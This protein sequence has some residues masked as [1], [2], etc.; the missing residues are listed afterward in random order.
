MRGNSY[1][2]NAATLGI[3]FNTAMKMALILVAA[4]ASVADIGSAQTFHKTKMLNSKGREVP[5]DLRFD[6]QS[7]LLTVKPRKSTIPDVP[8]GAIDKLSYERASHRR[9]KD[10]LGPSVIACA[11]TPVVY[12]TCPTSL[13]VGAVL[14]LTKGRN[15]WFY[16]DYQQDGAPK[17]LALRLD[18]SEYEQVLKTAHDQTGKA[19]EILVS[20]KRKSP[21]KKAWAV[22]QR[23]RR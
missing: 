15:H 21:A 11:D 9:T 12:L 7:K 23:A 22:G 18:K 20:E 8:Y 13:G 19:V 16:V 6:E 17:K 3:R 2:P 14:L 1:R 5:V 4:I 10:P